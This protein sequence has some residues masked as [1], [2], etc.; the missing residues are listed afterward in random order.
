MFLLLVFLLTALL[1]WRSHPR[2]FLAPGTDNCY[3][4]LDARTIRVRGYNY[5]QDVRHAEGFGF[6][7]VLPSLS[8]Q[9]LHRHNLSA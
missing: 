7:F 2:S 8:L 1:T 5:L 3:R 6:T 9:F 4:H